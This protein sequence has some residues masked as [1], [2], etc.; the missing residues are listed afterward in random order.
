MVTAQNQMIIEQQRK[1]QSKVKARNVF[2]N[3]T[4]SKEIKKNQNYTEVPVNSQ[5]DDVEMQDEDQKVESP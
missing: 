1:L 2:Q 5:I 3:S 4:P